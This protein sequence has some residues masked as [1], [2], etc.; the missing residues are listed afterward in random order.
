MLPGIKGF[1]KKIE[2]TKSHPL[3]THRAGKY[4]A[5]LDIDDDRLLIMVIEAG[6]DAGY[7]GNIDINYIISHEL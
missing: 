6:I 5:I 3:Y 7:T 1:V 2:G 4:R